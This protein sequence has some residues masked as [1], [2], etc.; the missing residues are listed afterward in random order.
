MSTSL[1][2]CQFG[3]ADGSKYY[4]SHEHRPTDRSERKCVWAQRNDELCPITAFLLFFAFSLRCQLSAARHRIVDI[5][6]VFQVKGFTALYVTRLIFVQPFPLWGL[7]GNS[8]STM[9]YCSRLETTTKA[10]LIGPEHFTSSYP[11]SF[12]RMRMWRGKHKEGYG[13]G[14]GQGVLIWLY[15]N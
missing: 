5:E 2:V 6:F 1:S 4:S 9:T 10:D 13:R 14:R 12:V 7:V 8:F 3:M 15:R 11:W